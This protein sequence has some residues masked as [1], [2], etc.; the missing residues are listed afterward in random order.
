VKAQNFH[1]ESVIANGTGAVRVTLNDTYVDLT[2]NQARRIA[3]ALLRA[4]A[5]VECDTL[6]IGFLTEK[7]G[8]ANPGELLRDYQEYRERK[9]RKRRRS[10]G[11]NMQ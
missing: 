10:G 8:I 11:G 3:D 6:W 2:P 5:T 9:W 1:V 4:A 7:A